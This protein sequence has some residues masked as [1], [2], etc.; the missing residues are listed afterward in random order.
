M[1][2]GER[3]VIDAQRGKKTEKREESKPVEAARPP[4]DV[5]RLNRE[6][7]TMLAAHLENVSAVD[8][9]FEVRSRSGRDVRAAKKAGD[10]VLLDSAMQE[11]NRADDAWREAKAKAKA[12]LEA[13]GK[14]FDDVEFG[15]QD[16]RSQ[17]RAE[18]VA[19]QEEFDANEATQEQHGNRESERQFVEH[20]DEAA[21]R[22]QTA[23]NEVHEA[24]MVAIARI[25]R[26]VEILEGVRVPGV[27]DV[28]EATEEWRQYLQFAMAGVEDA[29]AMVR[30][31]TRGG[32]AE[33]GDLARA[34]P[35]VTEQLQ[36][37]QMRL[38]TAQQKAETV[39][40]RIIRVD[41]HLI[42]EYAG[43]H[44]RELSNLA[45]SAHDV[46]ELAQMQ[47]RHAV[48]VWEEVREQA[49]HIA[50]QAA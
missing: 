33:F 23:D 10:T 13:L 16:V 5:R 29:T 40:P 8:A 41:T 6:Q 28:R 1:M 32:Q 12:S 49:A 11:G 38:V 2:R 30:N 48:G 36:E 4:L 21:R 45:R 31:A 37:A 20:A 19:S 7:R 42:G 46:V 26:A 47:L 43:D 18:L 34:M 3:M 25:R 50:R 17:L 22:L 27:R 35:I 14:D 39:L 9:A 15:R 24:S 44:S